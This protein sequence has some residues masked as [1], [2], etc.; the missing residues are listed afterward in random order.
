MLQRFCLMLLVSLQALAW[1][2]F[3]SEAFL[4]H[5]SKT[6]FSLSDFFKPFRPSTYKMSSSSVLQA[7][8][9]FLPVQYQKGVNSAFSG[10][11]YHIGDF[12]Q[13]GV[14][15]FL[16]HDG[17]HG[18]VAAIEDASPAAGVK[19]STVNVRTDATKFY[20]LPDSTPRAPY[21]QYYAGYENQQIIKKLPQW[22]TNY[23]AFRVADEYTRIVN[24]VTYDDWFL[25]S[26]SE[27]SLMFAMRA[28]INK[29]SKANGGAALLNVAFTGFNLPASLYLSSR[30]GEGSSTVAWSLNFFN[31]NQGTVNKVSP[32]AVRCVRAF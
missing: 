11:P 9:K 1:G 22:E 20:S 24:G 13:G 29:V 30:E 25:P 10:C 5:P 8:G 23:P 19:W 21:G 4:T 15:I 26:S 12:A 31:G 6:R 16:T 7:L 32:C 14:I 3:T 18:L 27:L 2:E 28:I 17:L